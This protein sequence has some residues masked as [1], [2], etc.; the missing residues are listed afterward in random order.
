[1]HERKGGDREERGIKESPTQSGRRGEGGEDE[2]KK[3]LGVAVSEE[4][5]LALS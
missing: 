1:M 2:S 4:R 3:A 5:S